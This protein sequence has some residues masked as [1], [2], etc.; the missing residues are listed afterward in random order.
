MMFRVKPKNIVLDAL[1]GDKTEI[2]NLDSALKLIH[3]GG[4][5]M[6]GIQM[7]L[8]LARED[9][10]NPKIHF[11]LGKLSMQ[12]GQYDKATARFDKVLLLDS[13]VVEA[14]YHMGLANINSGNLSD[15]MFHFEKYVNSGTDSAL[16]NESRKYINEL[17]N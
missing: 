9:S 13:T 7:L 15:A 17:K 2:S 5:P 1:V 8:K 16:V 11:E 12:S 6:D 3:S 14:H 10:L 4:N